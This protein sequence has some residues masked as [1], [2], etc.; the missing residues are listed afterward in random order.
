MQIYQQMLELQCRVPKTTPALS[1]V[2]F[3]FSP[4]Q[5]D[6]V[7]PIV[8]AIHYRRSIE[9]TKMGCIEIAFKVDDDF[10]N[11]REGIQ[12][13]F[14]VTRQYAARK[15]YPLNVTLNVRFVHNSACWLS[16]AFGAGHTCYIEVLS[17]AKNADWLRYSG[18]VGREWLALRNAI[19]HWAKEFAQIPGIIGHIKQQ[20][21]SNIARFNQIKSHLKVD[22]DNMFVNKMLA[23]VF[24]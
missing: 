12:M 19:P 11:V 7:V 16:P 8:E 5:R 24:C 1:P 13:C 22:P 17:R 3:A 20:L 21:G 10:A 18:D 15:E 9:V 4:S 23:D 6:Q 14:D 2:T